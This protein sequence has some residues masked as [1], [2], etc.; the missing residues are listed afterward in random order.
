MNLGSKGFQMMEML[1]R[2]P[3]SVISVEQFMEHIWGW[4]TEVEVNVVWVN[5]SQLRKQLQKLG[6]A[7]EIK[8]VRGAGYTLGGRN[9]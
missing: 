1:M 4:D 6:S 7:V 3:G 9:G 5:I 2:N 8:V